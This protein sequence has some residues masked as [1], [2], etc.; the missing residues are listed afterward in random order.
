MTV[1]QC[2]LDS[3]THGGAAVLVRVA[4]HDGSVPREKNAWMVVQPSG[5]FY[6]TIGG[7]ALEWD[8]QAQARR[9][10]QARDARFLSRAQ[11]LGPS[12]GQCC[13][14][15]VVLHFELFLAEDEAQL[16]YLAN[17]APST[18]LAAAIGPDGR[19]VRQVHD[20]GNISGRDGWIENYDAKPAP[21]LLFGAGHVAR[22]LVLAL[23]PLPFSVRWIDSRKD[24]FP[25]KVAAH[26]RCIYA[27]HPVEELANAPA[28]ASVLIMTHAHA[29][30]LAI[31]SAAIGATQF[32]YV[33]VIGS[34]TKRARFASQ[35]KKAGFSDGM[36]GQLICPIG[37]PGLRGK[38]P[39]VIAASIAADL[40]MRRLENSGDDNA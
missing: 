17:F 21:L 20:N 19:V 27:A 12:L 40:L 18:P 36:I 11:A 22:A 1:F 6:G 14:G 37:V 32:R 26:V 35:M 15:H 38:E 16:V 25:G 2:L 24:A 30:D 39:A 23:T 29:E 33:G 31:A 8:A 10:I 9:M 34:Q 4:D 3:V 13:G 5:A 7:G 28:G